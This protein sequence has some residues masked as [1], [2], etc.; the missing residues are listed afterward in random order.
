MVENQS[1][2]L[3]GSIPPSDTELNDLLLIVFV[4]CS[5]AIPFFFMVNIIDTM[6]FCSDDEL[7]E[8]NKTFF[9]CC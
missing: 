1:Y 7:G 9:D 8:K 3:H 5:P 4:P 6:I 2:K